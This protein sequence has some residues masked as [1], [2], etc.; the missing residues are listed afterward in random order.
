[1]VLSNLP[2]QPSSES[3]V[4]VGLRVGVQ[5][6]GPSFSW[7]CDPRQLTSPLWTSVFTPV[8]ASTSG[9][10]SRLVDVNPVSRADTPDT[11][12]GLGGLLA[13]CWLQGL[14]TQSGAGHGHRRQDPWEMQRG[15]L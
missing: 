14:E 12:A 3:P 1:M 9:V 4:Q 13:V 11:G 7:L 8:T 15:A 6:K 5:D 10:I 2:A